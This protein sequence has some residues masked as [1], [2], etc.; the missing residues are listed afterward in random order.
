MEKAAILVDELNAMEQL[1]EMG[2]EGFKRWSVFY[3]TIESILAHEYGSVEVSQRM[4][5]ACPSRQLDMEQY[6]RRMRFFNALEKDGIAVRQGNMG[7]RN[8]ELY[9]KGVDM[10]IG[11]DLYEFSLNCV[12]LLFLFSS[13]G[14]FLPAIKKA[15]EKGSRVIAFV[16]DFRP[17][18]SIREAADEVISLEDFL[19]LLPE[20]EIIYRNSDVA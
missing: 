8:G 5:S 15:Q 1:H 11:L 3:R 19:A 13:D 18:S 16:S 17:A 10:L 4:Y 2:I 9:Q 20:G 12:P 6:Y 14:D 7:T